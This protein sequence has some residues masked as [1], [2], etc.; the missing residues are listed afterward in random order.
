MFKLNS[1]Y[2]PA[3]D[4]PK[5][6]K[7]IL[8]HFEKW[9]NK[10]V[11]LW[12]T[13]TWKTFTM[14]NIINKLK[15]PTLVL[16]H[17][18]T[19]AAQL[20]TE[21]KWFFPENAV[22]YFV[23][24]FDYYQPESYIPEKDMYIEKDSAINSEIEMYRLAAM[25][26]LLSKKDVVIVSSV[27]AIYGLWTAELFVKSSI[28]FEIWKNYN[29]RTLKSKLLD[30]QYNPVKWD[31]IP[32]TFNFL[33]NILDIYSSVEDIVYRIHFDEETVVFIEKKD[34]TTWKDIWKTNKVTIWPATQFMQN[35]EWL[36]NLL[37]QIKQELTY[38]I[39]YFKKRNELLFA[40]RIQQRVEYDLK[41]IKE[42]W[43][44]NWIENYSRYFE[45]RV[46]AEP[47]QSLF[48]YFPNE[49]LLI[50]DESHMTIPQFQAMPSADRS[51]KLN[52]IN[53]WFRLPSALDHRPLFWEELEY[54]LQLKVGNWKL[55]KNLSNDLR[56]IY[57]E[58]IE[59]E[60]NLLNKDFHLD[61]Y[62]LIHL[63]SSLNKRR[64]KKVYI[65]FV[66]A[67]PAKYEIEISNN[68][69][70]EQIIRPTWLLDPITYIY[71]KDGNFLQ[72]EESLIKISKIN[73]S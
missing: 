3:W 40:Q 69:I 4:Q 73:H 57:N 51:R 55:Q 13:W 24:Y 34:P 18:K 56:K 28:T 58:I 5:A 54:L 44:V 29:F 22:N 66:S 27:S 8:N 11:L 50:I 64:K 12:A 2:K 53:Y 52:L 26:N 43:F 63:T 67:T 31:I 65:L 48:D 10:V 68:T 9:Q 47:P 1:P 45:R 49:F 25:S 21:F 72:L 6:I 71:P 70:V 15:L 7:E 19:L 41:M 20:T 33:W 37:E 30:I 35:M 14:A 60:S 38:R 17:N 42:T 39:K 59:I 16:S 32:G 46:P 36:D 62:E 23:S 61:S